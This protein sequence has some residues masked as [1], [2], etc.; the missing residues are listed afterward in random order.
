M[1][2]PLEWREDGDWPGV[3][4]MGNP[5]KPGYPDT[6]SLQRAEYALKKC[7]YRMLDIAQSCGV[8]VT[9]STSGIITEKHPAAIQRLHSWGTNFSP[10]VGRKVNCRSI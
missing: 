1:N 4:P 10:I 2:I 8:K 9:S 3:S 6:S 7:I 5:L